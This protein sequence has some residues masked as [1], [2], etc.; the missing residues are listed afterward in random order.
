MLHA[1]SLP[2]HS[3]DSEGLLADIIC[4]LSLCYLWRHTCVQLENCY[5][6]PRRRGAFARLQARQLRR[7]VATSSSSTTA[8]LGAIAEVQH[9]LDEAVAERDSLAAQLREVA[10]AAAAAEGARDRAAAEAERATEDKQLLQQ[11]LEALRAGLDEGSASA[12][13]ADARVAGL[14]VCCGWWGDMQRGRHL[15]P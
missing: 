10:A 8:S 13:A 5:Y 4:P 3:V 6:D 7:A 9:L 11:E 15:A 2:R 14:R 1:D 12:A